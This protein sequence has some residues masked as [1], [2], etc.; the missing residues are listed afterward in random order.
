MAKDVSIVFKASDNLSDSIKHMRKNVDRLSRDVSEYRKIQDKAFDKKTEI[1]FDITKAKQ[2]LKELERAVKNNVEGSEKAFKEKQKTIEQLNEEYRRMTQ[3][4]RDASKAERKLQEDIS[5]SSNYN[6]SRNSGT[7]PMLKS[8]AG[9]GLTSMLGGAISNSL[10]QQASSL[11]GST[12]GEAIGGVVGG[13][14]TGAAMGS[15]AG[16]I[17]VAVGSAVGGLTGAINAL[18]NKNERE[19][20]YFRD[21]VMNIYD[22]VNNDQQVS[23]EKGIV[24]SGKREQDM[25]SFSTLLDGKQNAYKFL[26]DIQNFSA[27]TP[28]VMNDLLGTSKGML[29][30]GY[31]QDEIIPM[32]TKI[33][34]TSSALGIDAQNQQMVVTALGRMKSSGKTSLEYINMLTERAIPAVDYLA[35][36]LGKSNQEIYEM[37]SKGAIDGAKASKIIVDAMGE[38]FKGNMEKQSATYEGMVSTLSDKWSQ[39]DMAMGEGYNEKRKEGMKEE[40]EQLNG[41]VGNMMKEA[42]RLIGE[43]QADLENNYQQSIIFAIKNAQNSD[44][45]LKAQQKNDGA[46]MGRILAEAKAKAEVDYKNSEEYKLKLEADK[47]LVQDIQDAMLEDEGYLKYG[48]EMA[49]QFEKGWAGAIQSAINRDVFEVEV[50]GKLISEKGSI[51]QKY[52]QHLVETSKTPY[53]MYP[54]Y[55]TG[56][57]RVPYDDYPV[58]LHEGEK[59]LTKAEADQADKGKSIKPFFDITVNNYSGNSYEITQEIVRELIKASETF[60]G[61]N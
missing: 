55:A 47:K 6:A 12:T 10:T 46:E 30:Y 61:D 16:P 59:I 26:T 49:R 37:I 48:E 54:G 19:D 43:F 45:Y 1:K 8:L 17:G 58:R 21:E 40:I 28:Y 35:E 18:A 38:Q 39:I 31:K 32:M 15:I 13:V 60:G 50:E 9:A 34:D 56:L 29:S 23:L 5:K 4:A 7:S 57:D 51:W 20:D 11:F 14:A 22:L 25:I 24:L 44:E 53:M 33:G 27:V 36:A 41:E 52:G 42:N 3:V 2:E